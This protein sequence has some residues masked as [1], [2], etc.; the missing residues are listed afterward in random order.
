VVHTSNCPRAVSD[1]RPP[2]KR[3]R[4]R[5]RPVADL[6]TPT[7]PLTLIRFMERTSVCRHAVLQLLDPILDDDD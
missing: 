3:Q 7:Y 2:R 1:E 6:A 5:G 4:E